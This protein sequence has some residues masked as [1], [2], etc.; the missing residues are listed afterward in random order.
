[1]KTQNIVLSLALLA[2]VPC[3]F[4]R[5]EDVVVSENIVKGGVKKSSHKLRQ[6]LRK[7]VKNQAL[8]KKALAAAATIEIEGDAASRNVKI[9]ATQE[10][11]LVL[12]V[13]LANQAD[14]V[15]L[16]NT[17]RASG[18][19][20]LGLDIVK[21][22]EG[23]E[24]RGV[25]LILEN[26]TIIIGLLQEILKINVDEINNEQKD[27]VVNDEV[28]GLQRILENQRQ[29]IDMANQVLARK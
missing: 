17:L 18:I 24:L 8:I 16:L 4:L 1:M 12:D 7:I 29:I 22:A 15:S 5:A 13:I 26:Q 20:R 27:I 21:L 6:L 3:G 11:R 10:P 2:S 28:E 19:E 9:S 23:E 25:Q 14:I